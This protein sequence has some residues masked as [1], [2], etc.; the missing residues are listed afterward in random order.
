MNKS[1]RTKTEREVKQLTKDI[2]ALKVEMEGILKAYDEARTKI[3]GMQARLTTLQQ[4][5]NAPQI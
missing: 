5:L 4:F 3:A 2:L 1:Q